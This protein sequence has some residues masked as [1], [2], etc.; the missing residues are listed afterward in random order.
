MQPSSLIFV[1]V[2]AIWAAYLVQYWVRR[3]DHLAT[4]RSVDRFS[5][6]MRVLDSH[7]LSQTTEPARSYA[8]SPTRAATASTSPAAST[9]RRDPNCTSA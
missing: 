5:A 7:R 9:S 8:V 2:V 6:A 1:L 3:R 4:I